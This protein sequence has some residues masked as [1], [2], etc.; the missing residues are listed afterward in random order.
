MLHFNELYRFGELFKRGATR[1]DFEPHPAFRYWIAIQCGRERPEPPLRVR[2][3][4]GKRPYD[5]VGSTILLHLVSPRL[6]TALR[7]GGITGWDTLSVD[8]GSFALIRGYEVLRILGRCGPI[9]DSQSERVILP[10]PTKSGRAVDG[11]RGL[12]FDPV[13]WDGSDIFGPPETGH[14]FMTKRTA[15]LVR[16]MK[17]SNASLEPLPAIE[18]LVL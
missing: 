9:D 17:P 2:E 15:D 11:W 8:T 14:I 6:R 12:Y 18:R 1:V 3:I 13:S 5:V 4:T 16:Q 7:S 10:P